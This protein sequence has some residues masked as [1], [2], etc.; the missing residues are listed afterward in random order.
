MTGSF[1]AKVD[2]LVL[3]RFRGDPSYTWIWSSLNF[4]V[5]VILGSFAGTM[6]KNDRNSV[7]VVYKLLIT[8]IVCI[9]TG[10]LWGLEM[11][12]INVCGQAA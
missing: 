2:G 6:M 8:G 1:A 10:L 9:V 3:G 5:T 7:K 11:P 12:I 4:G